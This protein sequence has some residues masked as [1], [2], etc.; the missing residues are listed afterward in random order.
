MA[1]IESSPE[2]VEQAQDIFARAEAM[3]GDDP[4][5]Q[6]RIALAKLPILYLKIEEGPAADTAG[7]LKLID[8]FEHT[9]Q[10]NKVKSVKSGF[11]APFRD[12]VIHAWRQQAMPPE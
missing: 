1:N 11:R 10:E 5:L 6:D 12:E 7:Y 4:K 2:F 8:E 9:A 3:A